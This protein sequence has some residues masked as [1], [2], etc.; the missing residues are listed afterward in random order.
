MISS[1]FFFLIM[2]I[3]RRMASTCLPP[4]PLLDQLSWT[5]GGTSS[6]F[7]KWGFKVP[8]ME[9]EFLPFSSLIRRIISQVLASVLWAEYQFTS[10]DDGGIGGIMDWNKEEEI[11]EKME[12]GEKSKECLTEMSENLKMQDGL[13]SEMV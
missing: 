4:G 2:A 8:N 10:P 1:D 7:W 5:W 9:P 13:G 3:A 11:L 12:M 6:P